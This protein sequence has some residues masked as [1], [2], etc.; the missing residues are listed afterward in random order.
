MSKNPLLYKMLVVGVIVI[1]VGLGVEPAFAIVD[2]N[3][4]LPDLIVEDF[5]LYSRIPEWGHYELWAKIK[6]IGNAQT[7]GVFHFKVIIFRLIFRKIPFPVRHWGDIYNFYNY[8][9]IPG[10]TQRFHLGSGNEIPRLRG[11]YRFYV[12][13]NMDKNIE[14]GNYDNNERYENRYKDRIYWW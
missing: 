1:F 2:N 3:D 10:E 12:V 8:T 4:D 14:E 6:N 7:M 11:Y 9:I 13:I 5:E